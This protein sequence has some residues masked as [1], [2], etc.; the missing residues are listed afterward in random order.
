MGPPYCVIFSCQKSRCVKKQEAC[1]L[2]GNML[3]TKMQI[4]G[5]LPL[6]IHYFRD[7]N[8]LIKNI[9]WMK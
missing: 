9:K 5:D 2:L 6:P 7:I 8:K 4:L 3:E 1:G